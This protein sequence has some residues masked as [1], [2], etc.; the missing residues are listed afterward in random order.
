MSQTNE[1]PELVLEIGACSCIRCHALEE[2]LNATALALEMCRSAKE[3][4]ED[5]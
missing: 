1:S 5:D 2:R 4:A 3:R